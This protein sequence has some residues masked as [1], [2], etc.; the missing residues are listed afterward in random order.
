MAHS[1]SGAM[2]FTR[3]GDPDTGEFG[4]AVALATSGEVPDD[5]SGL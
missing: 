4:D 3:S 5:L 1:K 2:A